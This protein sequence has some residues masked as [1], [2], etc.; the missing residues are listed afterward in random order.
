M[1]VGIDIIVEILALRLHPW[2]QPEFLDIIFIGSPLSGLAN[3]V[4]C[5]GYL[6]LLLKRSLIPYKIGRSE[7][8]PGID[9]PWP[10]AQDSKGQLIH[11]IYLLEPVFVGSC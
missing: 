3:V 9:F 8:R 11:H 10:I 7:T 2:G 6:H 4:E 5:L 1:R